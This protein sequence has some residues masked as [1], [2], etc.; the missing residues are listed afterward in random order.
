MPT[1]RAPETSSTARLT[2]SAEDI[3]IPVRPDPVKYRPPATLTTRAITP[4]RRPPQSVA[5]SSAGKK[6]MKGTR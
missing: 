1:I 2:T 6:V 4:P 5:A 3:A